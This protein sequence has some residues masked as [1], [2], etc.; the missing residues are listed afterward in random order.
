MNELQDLLSFA[1]QGTK[2]NRYTLDKWSD[3]KNCRPLKSSKATANALLTGYRQLDKTGRWKLIAVDLDHKDNWDE[4]ITTFKALELPQTLTVATPSGGYHLFYWVLKDIPVQNINDDRHCKNFELKGDNSNITAPGS[5]FKC[6]AS[7]KIVRDIPIARLL[8]GEAYRLCKYKKE[9]HP[10]V[11]TDKT[12]DSNDVEAV[13]R[14]YDPR[15]RHNPRGWS[16]RCPFH[17]DNR[18]SAIIFNSG[19][20]YCSGCGKNEKVVK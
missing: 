1:W 2:K 11:Y 16:I 3:D 7:Y 6:G 10:P 5:V 19:W 13:A 12:I 17:E 20:L 9:W 4:V 14:S 18:A 8:S 15:A